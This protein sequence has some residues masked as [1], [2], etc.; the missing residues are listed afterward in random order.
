[1]CDDAEFLNDIVSQLWPNINAAGCKMIKDIVDPM[2]KT[3]LPGPLSS[4]HFTKV[5]LGHVP[6]KIS[7]VKTAKTSHDGIKLDMN[8][9]WEGKCDMDLEGDMIPALV[10]FSVCRVNYT[11][12]TLC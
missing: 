7:H 6:L 1:M 12:L 4:L 10:R 3:T 5:D 8:V 9:H 2:F 11:E